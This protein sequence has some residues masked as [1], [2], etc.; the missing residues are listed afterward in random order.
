[1]LPFYATIDFSGSINK[2]Y[3]AILAVYYLIMLIQ[4]YRTPPQYNLSIYYFTV[5][6]EAILFWF[7]V[8]DCITA[9]LDFGS[10]DNIGLF[11][12]VIGIPFVSLMY[13]QLLWRRKMNLMKTSIKAFKKETDIEMYINILIELIESRDRA[14]SRIKLE[15]VLKL[16][17]KNCSKS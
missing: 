16:H 15:G 9:F 14:E 3:V 17:V 12:L 7:A 13:L 5:V 8:V 6:S 4:R 10:V 1:M 2:P 11:Y